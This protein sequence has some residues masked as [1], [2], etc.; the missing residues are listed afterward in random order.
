MPGRFRSRE[1]VFI[2]GSQCP[3]RLHLSNK[4]LFAEHRPGELRIIGFSL[5]RLASVTPKSVLGFGRAS[6]ELQPPWK[7]IDGGRFERRVAGI[8]R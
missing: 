4:L 8:R 3:S 7:I 2:H 5:E 1:R 6:D